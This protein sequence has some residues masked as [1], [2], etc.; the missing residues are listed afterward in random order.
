MT[1]N[2]IKWRKKY[3]WPTLAKIL[4]I[5]SQLQNFETKTLLL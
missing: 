4:R 5:Y 3:M 1:S 2:I